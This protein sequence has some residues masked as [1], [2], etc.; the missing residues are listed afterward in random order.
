MSM[1]LIGGS[2]GDKIAVTYRTA[3]W[4]DILN[5][6]VL[7]GWEPAGTERPRWFRLV[8]TPK[9]ERL[10]AE[11]LRIWGREVGNHEPIKVAYQ[12]ARVERS[13]VGSWNRDDHSADEAVIEA[14]DREPDDK[15][16]K[17]YDAWDGRYPGGYLTNEGQFVTAADATALALALELTLPDIPLES[18]IQS[19]PTF[20]ASAE[21]L[22]RAMSGLY[23][24]ENWPQ[25]LADAFQ[26][27]AGPGRA[28]VSEIIQ[29]CR[30]GGFTIL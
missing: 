5:L 16:N 22:K 20:V 9:A 23:R 6:A 29:L 10:M 14:S 28:V 27:L 4:I 26:R 18:V 15:V 8:P 12:A 2:G 21:E 3:L 7:A 11:R 19:Q 24:P 25:G 17:A 1:D 30:A 13:R